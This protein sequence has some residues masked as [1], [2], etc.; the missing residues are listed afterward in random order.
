MGQDGRRA[1]P[2]FD[3]DESGMEMQRVQRAVDAGLVLETLAPEPPVQRIDQGFQEFNVG[4]GDIDSAAEFRGLIGGLQ[5]FAGID[6]ALRDM[7]KQR[8]ERDEL[9][10]VG[11]AAVVDDDIERA[12]VAC[13][14]REKLR[15][16]LA[17]DFDVDAPAR[18]LGRVRV[19]RRRKRL[20]WA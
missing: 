2:L 11:V 15:V 14:A 5:I 1:A 10:R 7:G 16:R 9:V 20:I 8:L 19:K 12:V 4:A 17:A 6:P 18:V 13:D 3:D